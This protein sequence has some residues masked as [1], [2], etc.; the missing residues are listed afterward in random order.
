[1]PLTGVNSPGQDGRPGG[2]RAREDARSAG[3]SFPICQE[4]EIGAAQFPGVL[5]QSIEHCLNVQ[6]RGKLM[7]DIK[8]HAQRLS[9]AI[10][11]CGQIP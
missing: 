2:T 6:R 1:M 11:G 8:T 5:H 4:G 9:H 3:I 10:E 7:I